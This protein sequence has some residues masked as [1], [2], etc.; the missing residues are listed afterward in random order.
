MVQNKQNQETIRLPPMSLGEQQ[1]SGHCDPISSHRDIWGG[2]E[3]FWKE[4]CLVELGVRDA[5]LR[6]EWKL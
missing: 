1:V 4:S 3:E 2:G 5:Q 6:Y